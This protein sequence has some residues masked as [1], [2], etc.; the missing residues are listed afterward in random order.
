MDHSHSHRAFH[1][2][3]VREKTRARTEVGCD[4]SEGPDVRLIEQ[5]EAGHEAE[6]RRMWASSSH[7]GGPGEERPAR[8]EALPLRYS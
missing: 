8:Q 7:V 1:V 4:Y 5:S 2:C 6:G 3:L